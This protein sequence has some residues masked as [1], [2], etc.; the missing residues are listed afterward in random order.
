[1]QRSFSRGRFL[2]ACPR[3][4]GRTVLAYRAGALRRTDVEGVFMALLQMKDGTAIFY[5]DWG[6]G[7]AI[8]LIHGWPL[9]SAMW[10]YQAT[11]LAAEGYRVITYDRRGF[12]RS[13]QPWAGYDYDNLADDLATLLDAC[14]VEQATLVGFSM[15]GGE[16]ARYMTRHRGR[17]VARAVLVASVTP[18]LTK[19]DD[20][21]TGIDRSVFDGM[22]HAADS[23]RPA[24]VA[25]FARKLYGLNR[26]ALPEVG[27]NVSPELLAW[28]ERMALQASPRAT[29]ACIRA[30]SET[31]FRS[32][33]AAF[34]VPTLIIHG[35]ADDIVPIEASARPSAK[36]VPG[37]TLVVREGA[38]HGLFL[39]EKDRLTRALAEFARQGI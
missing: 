14:R 9:S 38:P 11:A 6:R 23:D 15:G 31:D 8:V 22:V 2:L 33:L 16:V 39:T 36:I 10:E 29:R 30:F 19:S 27:G 12:G 17:H 26:A 7:R 37:A 13:D 3:K 1:M 20:N 25:S 35:G 32:D 5:N 34:R 28:T 21:P 18:F 24:L 4:H